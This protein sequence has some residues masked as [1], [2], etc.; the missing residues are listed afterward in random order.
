LSV[1]PINHH[2]LELL[3][4][5]LEANAELGPTKNKPPPV[6]VVPPGAGLK[7]K[8]KEGLPVQVQDVDMKT[9]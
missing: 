9:G 5:A 1:D 4:L 3:N 6:G 7:S 8:A 2:I